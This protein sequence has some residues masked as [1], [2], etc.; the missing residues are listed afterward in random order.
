MSAEPDAVSLKVDF[1]NPHRDLVALAHELVR[2]FAWRV[3]HLGDVQKPLDAGGESHEHAERDDLRDSPVKD[4]TCL[5]SEPHEGS[6]RR[7]FRRS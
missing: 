3:G 1:R 5:I 6:S 4:M 2:A 7:A